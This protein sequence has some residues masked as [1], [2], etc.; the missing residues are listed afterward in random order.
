MQLR[1]WNRP[2]VANRLTAKCHLVDL[3]WLCIGMRSCLRRTVFNQYSRKYI[4][5][6]NQLVGHL[7]SVVCLRLGGPEARLKRGPLLWRHHTQPT[8]I[9]TLIKPKIRP[10]KDTLLRQWHDW[11]SR[12][13][14]CKRA[15]MIHN[16]EITESW[17]DKAGN[18]WKLSNSIL[19]SP[20]LYFH[21]PFH[22]PSIHYNVYPFKSFTLFPFDKM[23]GI[24]YPEFIHV[25]G[26]KWNH[27]QQPRRFKTKHLF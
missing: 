9:G 22:S 1:H 14:K 11:H 20:P 5:I 6:S 16:F 21:A 27:K 19:A 2:G 4:Q 8:V 10:P 24:W 18:T 23:L 7:Y 17:E 15:F 13:R 3:A 26:N 25:H 12:R